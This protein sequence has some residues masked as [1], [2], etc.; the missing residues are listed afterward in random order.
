MQGRFNKFCALHHGIHHLQT[1]VFKAD[2]HFVKQLQATEE[3]REKYLLLVLM[4]MQTE[5]V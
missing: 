5:C 3:E 1:L 2:V 4:L